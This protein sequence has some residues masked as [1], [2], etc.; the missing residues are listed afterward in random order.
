[1]VDQI[2]IVETET[3]T[4]VIID[5]E[6]GLIVEAENQDGEGPSDAV[7]IAAIQADA[8]VQIAEIDASV[9]LEE[10]S[11]ES[12]RETQWLA[13]N[14]E[15]EQLRANIAERNKTIA[16]L[17]SQLA[18]PLEPLEL[19]PQPL[20]GATEPETLEMAETN[21]TPQ[22]TSHQQ[23]ETQTEAIPESEGESLAVVETVTIRK[24][25]RLI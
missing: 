19:I 18:T 22:F 12:E 2:T 1:M 24:R 14:Q 13:V 8:S 9:R 15:L 16:E 6:T 7:A 5:G 11:A 4:P 17:E 23:S 10:I 21:L 20:T 3:E 25:R